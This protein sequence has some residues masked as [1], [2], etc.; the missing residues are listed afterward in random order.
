M[1]KVDMSLLQLRVEVIIRQHTA[2]CPLACP[3]SVL[4]GSWLHTIKNNN[5]K[6]PGKYIYDWNT[7]EYT[8]EYV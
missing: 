8:N 1:A 6:K 4:A 5:K 3:W 2:M 7:N